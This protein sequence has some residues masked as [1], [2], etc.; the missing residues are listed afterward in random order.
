M[1]QP[2]RRRLQIRKYETL[3]DALDLTNVS[4]LANDHEALNTVIVECENTTHEPSLSSVEFT[5]NFFHATDAEGKQRLLLACHMLDQ[6]QALLFGRTKTEALPCDDESLP[7]PQSQA[8]WDG[9]GSRRQSLADSVSWPV[10]N[11]G[12]SSQPVL[13]MHD[14]FQSMHMLGSFFDSRRDAAL[15][16]TFSRSDDML[17]L[18]IVEH[19][20][21]IRLAYHTFMLCDNTPIRSLLAVAGET[22]VIFEKLASEKE[23]VSAKIMLRDWATEQEDPHFGLMN[24]QRQQ[25]SV[26]ALQHALKILELHQSSP[27]TGV[28][29]QEW[30]VFLASLVIWAKAYAHAGDGTQYLS[31]VDNDYRET[32]PDLFSTIASL[33]ARGANRPIRFDDSIRCLLWCKAKIT[34]TNVAHSCGLVNAA[35][36]VLEKLLEKGTHP[37]WF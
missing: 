17:H 4:K 3:V 29:F 26:D 1:L 32:T 22:W 24:N 7:F 25:S 34:Q 20:S 2:L 31:P 37:G 9:I 19:S 10:H 11:L 30:A 8:S 16:R 28:L 12:L 15:E 33:S 35:L 27:R 5:G 36:G 6:Q 14:L 23:Y 13:Q 18:P 21:R